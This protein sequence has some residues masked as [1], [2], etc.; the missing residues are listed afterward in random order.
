VFSMR[1]LTSD[2][3]F[4]LD[5]TGAVVAWVDHNPTKPVVQLSDSHHLVG[6]ESI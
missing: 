2:S 5:L 3:Y 1:V 6:D 4:L